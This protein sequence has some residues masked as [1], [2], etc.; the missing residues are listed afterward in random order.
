MHLT[1]IGFGCQRKV[2]FWLKVRCDYLRGRSQRDGSF[3]D[4]LAVKA[5]SIALAWSLIPAPSATLPARRVP[6]GNGPRLAR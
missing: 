3:A 4:K 6:F 2:L 5:A 1:L